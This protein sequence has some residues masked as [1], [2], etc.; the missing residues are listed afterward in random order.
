MK[1]TLAI[2][3]LAS[4]MAVLCLPAAFA[5]NFGSVKGQAKDMDGKPIVGATVEFNNSDTGRKYDLKTNNKGEYFSLGLEP[6]KYKVTLN[7]DGKVLDSVTNFPVQLGDN[8]VDFDLKKSQTEAAQQ[9]GINPEQLK[10]MQEQQ[11]KAA[12]EKDTV[13][14]LN[15]KLAAATA[16]EQAGDFDAAIATLTEATQVDASRDLLWFKLGDAY[17]LSTAKVTD[18]D[19]KNKRLAASI[20]NIEKAVDMKKKGIDSGEDKSPDAPKQLAA[21]YNNLG[22]S[23]A[24]TGN[25]DGAVKA[26]NQAAQL[27]PPAAG[28]YY[29]NLGA[30]MTNANKANDPAMRKAAVEAFDKAIAADPSKADSY[31]WKGSNLIGMATLKDDKMVAPEGTAEAFQKYLDLS[32][33]GPHA[34]EAKAMLAGIGASVETSYGSKKKTTKK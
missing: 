1:K 16:S 26:Y 30:T 21:Y 24:K 17:R 3:V 19:E 18:N 5:Q 31:Y 13:K 9:K 32:P 14:S 4:A 20:A 6:G 29:F 34:E 25:T 10:K 15:D 33:S 7:Q 27:N 28:Q 23:Y 11:A 2:I 8:T 22:D 12:K